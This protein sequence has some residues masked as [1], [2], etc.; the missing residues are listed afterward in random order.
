MYMCWYVYWY[1]HG[2]R[3]AGRKYL[4]DIDT[5]TKNTF[6]SIL[7]RYIAQLYLDVIW[8]ESLE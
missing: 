1:F 5:G 8:Q 3:F 7:Y 4:F 6:T 2:I